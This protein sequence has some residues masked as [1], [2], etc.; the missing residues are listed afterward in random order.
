MEILR[1]W[2]RN[3]ADGPTSDYFEQMQAVLDE[4]CH[5]TVALISTQLEVPRDFRRQ[6]VNMANVTYVCIT[7]GFLMPQLMH[8]SKK[9][10][11]FECR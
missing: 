6:L 7:D 11:M 9:E 3:A 8:T 1:L 5:A 4:D 2:T 10:W